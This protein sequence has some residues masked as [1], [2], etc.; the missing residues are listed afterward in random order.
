MNPTELSLRQAAFEAFWGSER[1]WQDHC[2]ILADWLDDHGQEQEAEW[3]RVPW[4]MHFGHNFQSVGW[5]TCPYPGWMF[6][7]RHDYNLDWLL[8]APP[9]HLETA[10]RRDRGLGFII[11]QAPFEQSGYRLTLRHT[12]LRLL[13]HPGVQCSPSG[14]DQ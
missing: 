1:D 5:Q 14:S 10:S 8:W 3:L 12:W 13:G 2:G 4:V 11:N 6:T 9:G 7:H